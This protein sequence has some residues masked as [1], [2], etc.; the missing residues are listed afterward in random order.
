MIPGSTLKLAHTDAAV[1][2]INCMAIEAIGGT[3][4][5]TTL[6]EGGATSPLAAKTMAD[7][8]MWYSWSK[9]F[10]KINLATG[11]INYYMK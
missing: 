6:E 8:E 9:T 2:P 1:E 11:N 5:F 7:G 3:V 10:T 4:T